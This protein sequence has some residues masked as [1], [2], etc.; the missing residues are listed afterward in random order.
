[1]SLL[2]GVTSSKEPVGIRAVISGVEKVGKTTL[3]C[4][5]LV[6]DYINWCLRRIN[7]LE[8]TYKKEENPQSSL[9][10]I[11][12]EEQTR[13]QMEQGYLCTPALNDALHL[14]WG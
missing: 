2:A 12:I 3:V 14:S 9:E 11:L 6:F 4:K 1:M 7:Q 13:Y 10:Q 5:E 8:K